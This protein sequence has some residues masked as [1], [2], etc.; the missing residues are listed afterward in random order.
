MLDRM[1]RPDSVFL[2]IISAARK[3]LVRISTSCFIASA[4]GRLSLLRDA[5][6]AKGDHEHANLIDH[7]LLDSIRLYDSQRYPT[8][9]SA[10]AR[11]DSMLADPTTHGDVNLHLTAAGDGYGAL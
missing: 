6:R 7:A 9:Q 8:E 5:Y 1:R 2:F 11:L 10:R 4:P 3:S